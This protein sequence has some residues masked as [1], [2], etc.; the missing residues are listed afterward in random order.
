MEQKRTLWI[1]A[2]VGV[3][4]LAVI[5][6][7]LILYSPSQTVDS[8]IASLQVQND[9]WTK[10]ETSMLPVQNNTE[11]VVKDTPKPVEQENVALTPE[12][13]TIEELNVYAGT[14]N[15]YGTGITT[16]DLNALKYNADISQCGILYCFYD[17]RKKQMYGT[18]KVTVFNK[19]F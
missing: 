12:K 9:T 7:A 11:S 19:N 8:S 10:P 2:A 18:G 5:G 14:T 4:L 15:V 3:F 6:A 16:I 13:Q 1:I 17:G